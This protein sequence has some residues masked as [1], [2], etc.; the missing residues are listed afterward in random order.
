MRFSSG[1]G[2]RIRTCGCF[3]INGFQDRRFKPLSQSSIICSVFNSAQAKL[4]LA[5]NL[6]S[7]SL[8]QGHVVKQFCLFTYACEVDNLHCSTCVFVFASALWNKAIILIFDGFVN[9]T[10]VFFEKISFFLGFKAKKSCF[11]YFLVI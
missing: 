1:G 11:F 4:V 5:T 7:N 2:H 3:H 10:A 6:L 8:L 9:T